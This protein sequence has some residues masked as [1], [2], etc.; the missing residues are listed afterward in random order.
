MFLLFT[1][2]KLEGISLNLTTGTYHEEFDLSRQ[3]LDRTFNSGEE[4]S[5]TL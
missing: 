1:L 3:R 4:F 2:S 5:I